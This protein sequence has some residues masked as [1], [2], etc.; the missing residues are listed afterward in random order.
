MNEA[1]R[2]P[3]VGDEV[4]DLAKT[5]K[6]FPVR[7]G[8]KP[9]TAKEVTAVATELIAERQRLEGELSTSGAELTDL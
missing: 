3:V 2:T 4:K 9:W 8:E 5:A 6:K 1:L 7:T